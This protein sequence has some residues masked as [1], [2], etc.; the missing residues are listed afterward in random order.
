M[1]GR[2]WRADRGEKNEL[3]RTPPRGKPASQE[4]RKEIEA[5]PPLGPGKEGRLGESPS[6]SS[7]GPSSGHPCLPEAPW[8]HN[9]PFYRPHTCFALYSGAVT[10]RRSF[11][12][13]SSNC[14][15]SSMSYRLATR[16]DPILASHLVSI[17]V[18]HVLLLNFVIFFTLFLQLGMSSPALSTP[19]IL[20]SGKPNATSPMKSA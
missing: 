7:L 8:S 12:D 1:C 5:D 4:K 15:D 18:V 11:G 9:F 6:T 14:S 16:G 20:A 17:C 2:G 10:H 19:S 3:F 13:L